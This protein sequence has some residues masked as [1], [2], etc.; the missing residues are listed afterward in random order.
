VEVAEE[1]QVLLAGLQEQRQIKGWRYI[2]IRPLG[3]IQGATGNFRSSKTYC[4]HQLDLSPGIET[5][6]RGFQKDSTQRKIRRAERE[7]LRIEEGR[8]DSLL[9]AF[10]QLQLLTRQRHG[11]PP[12]PRSWYR[13]LV[14]C[15]GGALTIRVALKEKQPVAAII[16]LLFNKTLTYKYGCSDT[17]FNNLGGTQMLFWRSIQEAK[18]SNLQWFDLGRSD[19]DNPGLI[20]FKDR[21]GAQ[22]STL[23]YLRYPATPRPE[24]DSTWKMQ[25]AKRVFAHTPNAFLSSI[26]GI[27][28]RHMG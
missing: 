10:Y 20:T 8:S 5:L 11:L 13:N 4:F 24:R 2:E 7:N 26:G 27:L 6:F 14:E 22:R 1:Y 16:T 23:T 15:L 9:D 25:V 21:W 12:Q 17:Q 19:E 28:Y 18:K 3:A